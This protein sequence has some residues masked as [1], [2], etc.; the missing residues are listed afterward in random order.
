[1][2][3]INL[4]PGDGKKKRRAKST[5]ATKFEFNLKPPAWLAGLTEGITDKYM[6]GAI[7]AAGLSGALI[8]L[9]FIS[10]TAAWPEALY[11]ATSSLPS[12]LKSPAP[13]I[14]QSVP[15]AGAMTSGPPVIALL[16]PS[17]MMMSL[18]LLPMTF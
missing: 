5:V 10:Q 12:P 16:F 4:L 18:P 13:P 14:V 15:I 8:V 2:I 7:G 3:E 17:P 11:Q 1:M 6:L 9:L